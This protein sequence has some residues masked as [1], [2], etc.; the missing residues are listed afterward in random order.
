[1]IRVFYHRGQR[2]EGRTLIDILTSLAGGEGR[3]REHVLY[4]GGSFKGL[5]VPITVARYLNFCN[6]FL[7]KVQNL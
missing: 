7:Y 1:M 6:L 4:C 5:A 2:Q 3:G